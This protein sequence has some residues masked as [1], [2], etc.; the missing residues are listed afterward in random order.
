[1]KIITLF[2]GLWL[3]AFAGPVWLNDFNEAKILASKNQQYILINFAGTDWCG[4]CITM[5]K[6]IFGDEAFASY[7]EKHLVL[8]R[9]DFPRLKKNLPSKEQIAKNEELASR[10][11]KDGKFPYTVLVD[12]TG[13]VIKQWDGLPDEKAAGFVQDIVAV[14]HVNP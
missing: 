2:L 11:N 14:T 10:Y 9:A 5:R 1:M 6:E 12:A 3:N 8:L 13:R 4:P 7:A